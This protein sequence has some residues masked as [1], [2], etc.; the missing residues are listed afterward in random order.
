EALPTPRRRSPTDRGDPRHSRRASA[1][2]TPATDRR[3]GFRQHQIPAAHRPL[4]TAWLTRLP[5]RVEADRLD[6]Q[7]TQ[8]LARDPGPGC[9]LT[10]PPRTRRLAETNADRARRP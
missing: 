4:P 5:G 6:A 8:A 10:R 2:P 7:P 1:L 9:H 3:A